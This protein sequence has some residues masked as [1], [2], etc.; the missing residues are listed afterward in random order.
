MRTLLFPVVALA[1]V[2]A[3][4][5]SAE[6]GKKSYDPKRVGALL[7]GLGDP[8]FAVRQN[9]EKDLVK[10]GEPA[11]LLVRK[12]I[13]TTTV[14]EVWRRAERVERAI[15][16][17][18]C[19][20]KGCGLKLTV[21]DPGEFEMGSPER[22]AGRWPDETQHTVRLNRTFLIGKH[23]VTQAEYQ[24]VT[25][26]NPSYFS[27]TGGGKEKLKDAP[28]PDRF[29]VEQVSWFD[30]LAFCN[31]LSEADGFPA[32]YDLTDTKAD[33]DS[34]ASA[35]VKVLGGNGYRLPTEAEWEYTARATVPFPYSFGGV[36]AGL[37]NFKSMVSVG[38][39]GSEERPSLG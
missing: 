39:G 5:L 2:V 28:N 13:D 35:T 36:R 9:A 6:D 3:A 22:E 19:T 7:D 31:K 21:A 33:G 30:A 17:G 11:L 34:I 26:G 20:S 29:P 18:C 37:G 16:W 32:Y 12:A 38:Y 8:V 27:Y 1:I 23:E 15:L 25:G 10:V 4:P 14:P 24:K